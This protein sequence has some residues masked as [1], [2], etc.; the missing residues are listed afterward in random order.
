MENVSRAWSFHDFSPHL[1]CC[2][3]S[4]ALFVCPEVFEVLHPTIASRNARLCLLAGQ[5]QE[6]HR[7][8]STPEVDGWCRNI[9]AYQVA[10]NEGYQ[11]AK[12][13]PINKEN[14]SDV[15]RYIP[16]YTTI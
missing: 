7:D 6:K 3:V 15:E 1:F 11:H 12:A 9:P 4:S 14:K 13:F 8:G 5:P 10:S 2:A 16:Y